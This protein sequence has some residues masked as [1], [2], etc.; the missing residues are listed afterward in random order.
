MVISKTKQL[1]FTAL[2]VALGL[3][4]PMTFHF[5]PN[6]GSV[7]LPM[8]IPVLL[9]GLLCGW[10]WGLLC[11]ALT[12]FL[13]SMLTGMPPAAILPAMLCELAVYGLVTGLLFKVIRCGKPVLDLYASLIGG[14]MAGRLVSG[15]VKAL[16]FNVGSYSM[17]VWVMASFVTALPGIVIQLVLIPV[18]VETLRRARIV[19]RA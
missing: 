3:I 10:Q 12:P 14:M 9:C 15:L 1:T 2:C 16:I 8:H 6:A 17:Q 11:G 7:F 5:V 19:A 18:V 13:S 4:L